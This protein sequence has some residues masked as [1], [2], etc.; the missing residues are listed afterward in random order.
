M[1]HTEA[2]ISGWQEKQ[3]N[4]QNNEKKKL[5]LRHHITNNNDILL[6]LSFLRP[7]WH[8]HQQHRTHLFLVQPEVVNLCVNHSEDSRSL[9]GSVPDPCQSRFSLSSHLGWETSRVENANGRL[10]CPQWGRQQMPCQ[11]EKK[12]KTFLESSPLES[13][14]DHI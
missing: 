7:L 3:T 5:K 2:G 8:R 12:K 13:R 10:W 6:P 14:R 11:V 9:S 1:C 4:K